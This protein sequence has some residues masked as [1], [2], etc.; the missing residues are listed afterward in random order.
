MIAESLTVQ[1]LSR[2]FK[3]ELGDYGVR[4]IKSLIQKIGDYGDVAV[5]LR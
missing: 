5:H 4:E 2:Y 1:S 3:S